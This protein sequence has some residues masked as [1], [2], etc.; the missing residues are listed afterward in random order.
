MNEQSFRELYRQAVGEPPPSHAV[1]RLRLP[2][3]EAD[4]R[5][6]PR[7][8]VLAAGTLAILVVA[9]LVGPRAFHRAAT[10]N[11]PGSVAS[12]VPATTPDTIPDFKACKLPVTVQGTSGGPEQQMPLLTTEGGFVDTRTGMYTR[13][14]AYTRNPGTLAEYSASLKRWLPTSRTMVALDQRSYL[15]KKL[16]PYDPYDPERIQAV[17]P[18]GPA[19]KAYLDKALSD[20]RS[21]ELHLVDPVAG[22]DRLIWSYPGFISVLLWDGG[23]VL[24]ETS[25]PGGG[26][27]FG[28]WRIGL[29]TG[30]AT[31]QPA[32]AAKGLSPYALEPGE[33]PGGYSSTMIRYDGRWQWLYIQGIQGTEGPISVYYQDRDGHRVTIYRGTGVGW[34]LIW[35]AGD[36]TGI[37]FG[38]RSDGSL[39]LTHLDARSGLTSI[40]LSGL[41][42]PP[43]GDNRH[44]EVMPAGPC[45][46]EHTKLG[47]A[48]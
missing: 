36:R 22:T 38:A 29:A 3:A 18:K 1:E 8:A 20:F 31:M 21:T 19:Y 27:P 33:V 10:P 43:P 39:S 26:S 14:P 13:D 17:M 32:S 5:R 16:L 12:P 47:P 41:P 24:V 46:S 45:I 35:P 42:Q 28:W 4:P 11:S 34:I 25:S 30:T 44:L 7:L 2:V 15:S 40:P 23:E 9:A 37:W 6:V 48:T